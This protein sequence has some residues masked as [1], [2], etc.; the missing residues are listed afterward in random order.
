MKS[1]AAI[2]GKK[3]F[4]LFWV[5]AIVF[6]VVWLVIAGAPFV[7]QIFT[8]LK[9]Q[10]EFITGGLFKIPDRLSFENYATVMQ[11]G[12]YRYFVNSVIVLAVSLTLLLFISA[13]AAYPLSRMQ[14]KLNRP[15]FGAIVATMSIPIH[16]TLIPVFMMSIR[17]N[18]Y[19]NVIAVIGPNVAFNLP[20]SIFILTAFMQGLS[21]EI[22]EAAEI[23]G[24]GKF[25]AFF[26]VIFPLS[27]SG[28]ATLGIYNGVVIWNEFIFVMILTQSQKSRTLPLA[29]WEY[30]GQY[31]MN[32][33]L[34]MAL[35]VLSSLPVILLYVFGQ[36]KLVK[37]MMAGAVKG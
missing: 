4:S 5:L 33:P 28:L 11:G 32:T 30:Q 26:K 15:I 17:M 31:S 12:F 37:G 21:K 36:D 23:D 18:V 3:K 25:A 16:I 24:C 7:F 19:D 6:A 14:F 8:S 9:T 2:Y 29:I 1:N 27:K 10:G 34:I 22:E 35:L 13:F 20:M